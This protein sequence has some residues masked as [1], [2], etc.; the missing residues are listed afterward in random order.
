MTENT[1]Q[2]GRSEERVA[3]AKWPWLLLGALV[4]GGVWIGIDALRK[5]EPGG[6]GSGGMGMGEMS[7][8]PPATVIVESVREE[9][10]QQRRQVTGSLRAVDRAEVAAQESGAVAEVRVDVGDRVKQGDVLVLLDERR[11]KATLAE[12]ESRATAAAAVV[13]E[14]KAE[15]TRAMLDLESKEN[16]FRERA[17]SEREY[18]DARRSASVAQARVKAAEDEKKASESALDLLEVRVEDLEVKAPFEGV[19]VDR[20]VDPGEWVA[21]GEAVIT[22]VST[23]IIEAWIRVPERFIGRVNEGA[24]TLE[25]V[26]D[27]SNLRAPAISIREIGEIDAT[28][29]LFPVVV[30][31]DDQKGA[32]VP[33]Q[34]VHADL[35]VGEKATLLV[36]PVDSV[37]ESFAGASV[38]R[39]SEGGA[40]Q[41][42]VATRVPVEVAF[43]R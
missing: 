4:V 37:I 42:P 29:R 28:T 36:V 20:Q 21:P 31:V 41:L 5:A 17:V 15:E 1:E 38:F 33:G 9:R 16:L 26:V 35:P 24:E 6:A 39:V 10:V 43:R 22:V 3:S 30:K 32:L 8:P 27:G 11:L 25:V 23:G 2:A 34:S 7:G 18:L 19:V 40:E 13:E 12:A 14:R